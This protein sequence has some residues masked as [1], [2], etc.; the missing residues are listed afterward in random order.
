MRKSYKFLA[1]YLGEGL[2]RLIKRL[3]NGNIMKICKIT[4][5]VEKVDTEKFIGSQL[6]KF[7]GGSFRAHLSQNSHLNY[8]THCYR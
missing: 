6:M 2:V 3:A 7:N 4:L 8:D 5:D 1:F